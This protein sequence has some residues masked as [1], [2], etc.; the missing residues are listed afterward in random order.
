MNG[1][2]WY[3][4]NYDRPHT[5]N[6]NM[7]IDVDRHN[8]FGFTLVYSTGRPYSAP[9]GYVNIDGAQYPVLWHPQQRAAPR[10]PPAR[11]HLE[12]L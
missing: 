5:V 12:H 2:N 10:L 11:F 1:G 4:A 9:T 6:A 7:T 8:S 3:R